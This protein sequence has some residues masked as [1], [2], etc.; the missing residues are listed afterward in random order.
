MFQQESKLSSTILK[1][2][3]LYFFFDELSRAEDLFKACL[4][5][6]ILEKQQPI[7]C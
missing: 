5:C 1:S 4:L 6:W 7:R 2:Q 3:E